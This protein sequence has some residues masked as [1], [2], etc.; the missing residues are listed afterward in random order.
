MLLCSL[1][2]R[3]T[4]NLVRF[5]VDDVDFAV[6][7]SPFA[8]RLLLLA[9][10]YL[11]LQEQSTWGFTAWHL[12]IVIAVLTPWSKHG[13]LGPRDFCLGFVADINAVLTPL[14]KLSLYSCTSLVLSVTSLTG[15]LPCLGMVLISWVR[16]PFFVVR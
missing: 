14:L 9:V 5:G 7:C 10:H 13:P 3:G 8:F 11:S 16:A 1:I 2:V 4:V 12:M 15:G 6:H